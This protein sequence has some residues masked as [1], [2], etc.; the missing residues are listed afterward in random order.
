MRKY[1]LPQSG[2]FYKANLHCHSDISDGELTVEEL[3]EAYMNEGYS[4]IAF[5]DHDEFFT[6]NDLTD[7]NFI[8]INS[9]EANISD[10]IVKSG[11]LRRCYHFCC[12]AQTPEEKYKEIK[13][14]PNY[15]DKNA[16]NNFIKELND[17]GF[18]VA[19]N[20]PNWSLQ[21]M[22]DTKWLKGLW[23]C[24]VFNYSAII[25]GIDGNQEFMYDII[26]REGNRLCCIAT[27]DNHNKHPFSHEQ[28]DSF[29][30]F[31][32]IKAEELSYKGIIGAMKRGDCYASSGPSIDELYIEDGIVHVACS[33]ARH[34]RF[35]T[36]GRSS[37]S[38]NSVNDN[39]ITH[40]EYKINDETK[41]V[42]VQITGPDGTIANSNAYWVKDYE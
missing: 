4:V 39:F 40:G 24:E 38:V 28:N 10:T 11:H 23:G 27:D 9:Y 16:V 18:L 21:T 36:D 6:H 13:P 32:M 20:H 26:L 42:R 35:T 29:G 7:K 8:A 15:S 5:T 17:D 31:T 2:N 33:P 14:I 41:Y 37:K 22:E 30:G 19:Y 3:K 12:Y 1:L 34:I 25:D